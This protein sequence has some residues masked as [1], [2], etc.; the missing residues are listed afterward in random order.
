MKTQTGGPGYYRQMNHQLG[1]S[2]VQLTGR[3]M[4][5]G[6]RTTTKAGRVLGVRPKTVHMLVAGP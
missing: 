2:L 6:A 1:S 3:L 5:S 4:A